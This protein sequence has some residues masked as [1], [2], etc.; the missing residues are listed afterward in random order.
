MWP[1]GIGLKV[2]WALS[3]IT[4]AAYT[5]PPDFEPIHF[6]GPV[7]LAEIS[8]G[9]APL[10]LLISL[11]I[12]AA[13]WMLQRLF[14]RPTA[15]AA[16]FLL[17]LSP[18]YLTQSKVLHLDAW[19]ATLMLLSALALLL[20]R[21]RAVLPPLVLAFLAAFILP[22]GIFELPA[23]ILTTGLALRIG[24]VPISPPSELSLGE[25][26]LLALADWFKV[27]VFLV[28]PLLLVAAFIEANITPL[29]VL[30]IYGS[31]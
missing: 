14:D 4:P 16:G 22:H 6:F 13:W 25:G 7:P 8:A 3:G 9:I 21:F 18:Y 29:M 15:T 28:L 5:V 12:V 26:M 31:R 19:M 1:V 10:A 27:V 30:W 2:Y 17:A 20:Y 23:A 24:V 11:G